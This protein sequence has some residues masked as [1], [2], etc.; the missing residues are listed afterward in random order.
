MVFSLYSSRSLNFREAGI[1]ISV[2]SS[3]RGIHDS[4]GK[5]SENSVGAARATHSG[6]GEIGTKP[7]HPLATN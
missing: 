6:T 7:R 5:S 1:T 2:Y 3:I 4:E